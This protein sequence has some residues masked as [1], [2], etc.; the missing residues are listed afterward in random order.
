[1]FSAWSIIQG[2]E[3]ERKKTLNFIREALREIKE[4]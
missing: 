2:K 3:D 1:M 4:K